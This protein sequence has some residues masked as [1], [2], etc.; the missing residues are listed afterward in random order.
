MTQEDWYTAFSVLL[1]GSHTGI[2]DESSHLDHRNRTKVVECLSQFMVDTLGVV[3][4]AKE[5]G[6]GEEEEKVVSG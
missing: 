3:L 6:G 1:R 4:D 5:E 2:Q